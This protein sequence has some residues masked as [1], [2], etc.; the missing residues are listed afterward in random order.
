MKGLS[1]FVVSIVL[2]F[3]LLSNAEPCGPGYIS[4]V[5]DRKNA[6]EYPYSGYASGQLGIVKPTYRRSLLFAAY[7]Y[8]NGGGFSPDDQAAMIDLWQKTVDRDYPTQDNVDEVV[9]AW[10]EKRKEIVPKEEKLPQVYVERSYGGYDFF[11][12]CAKNAFETA[13]ETLADRV[14][15]HGPN[16]ASVQEWLNGQDT[17]FQNCSSGRAMPQDAPVGS[18]IWLQKDREYQK[19]AAEFYALDYEGA[20]RRFA[21]IAQ[22]TESPWAETADYLVC[23]TLIRQA[24]LSPSAIAAKPI[25][26]EA[27][28]K[29][30]RFSSRTGKFAASAQRLL[31]LVNFRL[32][33]KERTSELAKILA[34]QSGNDNFKQDLI[35]YTWLLD[36]FE[37]ETFSAEAKKKAAAEA[38]KEGRPV[39]TPE[40]EPT[41]KDTI[42]NLEFNFYSADYSKSWT[43]KLK[44]D[45]TDEQ[46]IA[47]VE[48]QVG[49]P[50]TDEQKKNVREARAT[51]YAGRFGENRMSEYEGGYY[52]DDEL[53]L[54]ALPAFLRADD[55]TD[56]LF[57]FQTNTPEAYLHSLKRFRETN[58]DAWLVAAISKGQTSFS[59]LPTLLEAANNVS[60]MSPAYSTV[61]FHRA[62]LLLDLGKQAEAKKVIDDAMQFEDKLPI[63]TK[64]SF[65]DLR[66]RVSETLDDFLT[67]SMRKPYAW[68]FS[69][70]VSD[71]DTIIAREK[72]Y[73]DP[74]Y[75]KEGREAYD[76]EIEDR[77]K[78]E[79]EWQ[80]RV[81]LD[82]AAIDLMNRAF[83]LPV[84]KTVEKS[85]A[86]PDYLR[87][88]FAVAIWTRAWLLDDTASLLAITPAIAKE[89]P[90]LA[91]EL[92]KITS[93]TTQPAQD[94]AILYFVLK[95]PIMSPYIEDGIGKS[96]NEFGMWDS[97]DWWCSSY[98]SES[99]D[100]TITFDGYPR[101]TTPKFL[102]AAQKLAASNERKRLIALGDAPD[103]LGNKVLAWAKR[104]PTD[105]RVPEALYI[106]HE[107]NGWTKYGCGNNEDLQNQI[108]ALMKRA[109]PSS[110][111]TRK[112]DEEKTDGN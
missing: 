73:F 86:L 29:L 61:A 55:L 83:P 98:L 21:D 97:N 69:G 40:P 54:A 1:R 110:E 58:S 71:V 82:S 33:P 35:D 14:S 63:S 109:Y 3:G 70:S 90:E 112:L 45:A 4:P 15:A 108:K 46:A 27:E 49:K 77:Y 44:P 72:T 18:P 96:D 51:A 12:N 99:D 39:P 9:K 67:N 74:E 25:Y 59:Q 31:G 17:V 23:R 10:I 28:A 87:M 42:N 38:I 37:A 52:S 19:A 5:F 11:P 76:K 57:T 36:K 68:D 88:K 93:A 53:N 94:A 66:R 2:L 65:G 8:L 81:L 26:E 111:W 103:F 34:F 105:K 43:I 84:L 56:W 106:V 48:R 75:N 101:L 92:E 50:L 102:T 16:N 24:S 107:A 13:T 91:D 95:N 100:E 7:R 78:E 30:S 79:R 62:R 64:N 32:H 60:I 85:N 20:K 6:P 89:M 104:S 41:P 47:E 22:D 80:N